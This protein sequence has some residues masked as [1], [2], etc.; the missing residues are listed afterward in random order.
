MT[1]AGIT[2]EAQKAGLKNISTPTCSVAGVAVTNGATARCFA[3]YMRIHALEATGGFV[4]AQMEMYL[5]KP[6]TPSTQLL[7]GGGTDN[8][9]YAQLDAVTK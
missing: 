5:A 2:A 3:A 9:Q 7:A 1:P 8:T 4:Y 6:T